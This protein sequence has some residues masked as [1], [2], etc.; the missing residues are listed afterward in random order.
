M[1]NPVTTSNLRSSVR[2]ILQQTNRLIALF[3][4]GHWEIAI[5]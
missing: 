3:I 1:V 5:N 2:N 4:R